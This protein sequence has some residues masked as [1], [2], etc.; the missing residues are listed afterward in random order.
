MTDLGRRIAIVGAAG[1]GKSTLAFRL[2]ERLHLPLY[3]TDQFIWSNGWGKAKTN[4]D[5]IAFV[6]S[7]IHQPEWL[8]EGYLGYLYEDDKRLQNATTVI[9]LDY[10]RW[11]MSWHI[12]K[13]NWQYHNIK[14]PEMPD[15]CIEHFGWHTL[16]WVFK[17]FTKRDL[18]K[19]MHNWIQHVPPE[20]RLV[21]K[22]PR[23][24]ET[25]LLTRRI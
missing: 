6:D 23:Q 18:R 3:H 21:F 16:R 17:H 8:L 19:N 20:K 25:W 2:N 9:V 22:S 1:A 14:R 7:I 15:P 12:V 4:Q 13:R 24:L 5:I 10:N 11:R